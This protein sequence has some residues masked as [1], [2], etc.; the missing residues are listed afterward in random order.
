MICQFY[1]L[2]DIRKNAERHLDT[3]N[4]SKSQMN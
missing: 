2:G 4:T 3:G 1:S